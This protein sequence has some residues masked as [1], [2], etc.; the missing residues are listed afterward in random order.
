MFSKPNKSTTSSESIEA[1]G[2]RVLAASLIAENV[3]LHGDVAS[4]GDV[5][6]D[7]TIRGDVRIG[8][9]TIGET[10]RIEGVID[11][12]TVDIRG[13]VIGSITAKTV[14]LRATARVQGDITHAQMSVEAG[15]RFIGR[16][17]VYET[18][19][20]LEQAALAAPEPPLADVTAE[21]V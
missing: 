7:G 5:Q 18:N 9:L 17:L 16:S 10:G 19:P 15:A 21:E 4:D 14:R 12:Q 3:V 6:L 1:Q 20:R 13:E 8:Q 11:A 2:R